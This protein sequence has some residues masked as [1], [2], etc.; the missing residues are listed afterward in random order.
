MYTCI[1]IYIYIYTHMYV[2]VSLSLYL[3]I[4]IYIYTHFSLLHDTYIYIYIYISKY[5]DQFSGGVLCVETAAPCNDIACFWSIS[6]FELNIRN[7]FALLRSQCWHT[8]AQHIWGPVFGRRP[9]P[10]IS[11]S[12]SPSLTHSLSLTLTHSHSLSLW[13]CMFESTLW[14]RHAHGLFEHVPSLFLYKHEQQLHKQQIKQPTTC[15]T[16]T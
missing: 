12:L 10:L 14:L 7:I 1:C 15:I 16:N 3:Y 4:Y 5:E 9:L 8:N 11:L 6:T 2:C 13:A